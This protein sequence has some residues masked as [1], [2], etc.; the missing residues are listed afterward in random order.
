M[1]PGIPGVSGT[2]GVIAPIIGNDTGGRAIRPGCGKGAGCDGRGASAGR[3][4]APCIHGEAVSCIGAMWVMSGMTCG[5]GGKGESTG[6]GMG[7]STGA[8]GAIR[9]VWNADVYCDGSVGTMNE[10]GPHGVCRS[11]CTLRIRPLY[12]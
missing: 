2:P 12:S 3:D 8:G 5:C 6:A 11:K 1:K 4:A 9:R 10:A 7:G